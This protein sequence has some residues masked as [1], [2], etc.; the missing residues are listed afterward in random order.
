M[1]RSALVYASDKLIV[2]AR[3]TSAPVAALGWTAEDDQ[4][5]QI[6]HQMDA[7]TFTSGALPPKWVPNTHDLV[8][9]FSVNWHGLFDA[10]LTG[11]HLKSA[12]EVIAGRSDA[13]KFKVFIIVKKTDE[14]R[15]R[16]AATDIVW[17]RS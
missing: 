16:E 8:D 9:C 13:A 15:A 10:A 5:I 4:A 1:T 3:E 2:I 7:N 12:A 11:S 17:N 6:A 14:K